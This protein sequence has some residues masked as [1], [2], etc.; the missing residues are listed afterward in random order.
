VN[1][2][3]NLM[4]WRNNF[5]NLPVTQAPAAPVHVQARGQPTRPAPRKNKADEDKLAA[6]EAEM[7]L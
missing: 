7:A 2:K 1:W 5:Y 3:L 6:L 4:S